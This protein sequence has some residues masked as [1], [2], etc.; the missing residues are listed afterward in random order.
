MYIKV[1]FF[2][3]SGKTK[4][5]RNKKSEE[6]TLWRLVSGA[7]APCADYISV[8]AAVCAQPKKDLLY[9]VW[10]LNDLKS[11]FFFSDASIK[12][13]LWPPKIGVFASFG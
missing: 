10:A 5:D 11:T 13:W 8:V 1:L 2:T 3:F 12:P 4:F 9:Q 7:V 6:L